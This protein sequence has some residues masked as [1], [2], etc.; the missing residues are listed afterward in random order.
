MTG[1][2]Y[3]TSV[4]CEFYDLISGRCSVY[5]NRFEINP[6][7]TKIT[8][9]NSAE[10]SWL[11]N[12][13]NYRRACENR[14]LGKDTLAIESGKERLEAILGCEVV[15]YRKDIDLNEHIVFCQYG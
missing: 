6:L 15:A 11:P 14:P 5:E 4:V 8:P 2:I 12:F 7:C 13:C 9:A 10:L 3:T 1:A